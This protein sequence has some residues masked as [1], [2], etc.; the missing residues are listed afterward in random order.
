MPTT[1]ARNVC[2][3]ASLSRS[4]E[5]GEGR[6]HPAPVQYSY[7]TFPYSHALRRR[8]L[9]LPRNCGDMPASRQRARVAPAEAGRSGA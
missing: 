3:T 8:A 5:G 7:S 6:A 4:K 1:L 2:T 9:Q